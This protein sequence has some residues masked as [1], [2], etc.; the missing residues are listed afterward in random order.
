M[1]ALK[2]VSRPCVR[3][4][5]F[6]FMQVCLLLCQG[7]NCKHD[8]AKHAFTVADAHVPVCIREL[9]SFMDATRCPRTRQTA[10]AHAHTQ[11]YSHAPNTCTKEMKRGFDMKMKHMESFDAMATFREQEL[12]RREVEL[13]GKEVHL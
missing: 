8:F 13:D 7:C 6:I 11:I 4:H 9:M 3:S 1:N 5:V 2:G 12:Q 10:S